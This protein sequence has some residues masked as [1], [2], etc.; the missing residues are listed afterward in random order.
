M[1]GILPDTWAFTP[2]SPGIQKV[3]STRY[4]HSKSPT[5][6]TLIKS[7]LKELF[8]RRGRYVEDEKGG[9][10]SYITLGPVRSASVPAGWLAAHS[11]NGYRAARMER[12]YWLQAG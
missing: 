10:L 2:G 7:F 9:R 1:P 4:F 3:L 5:M 11:V 12:A 8:L 6:R